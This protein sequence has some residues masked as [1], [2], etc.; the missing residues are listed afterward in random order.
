MLTRSAGR[1][2]DVLQASN[3]KHA[4]FGLIKCEH[5]LE[6]AQQVTYCYCFL[7]LLRYVPCDVVNISNITNHSTFS[8]NALQPSSFERQSINLTVRIFND[9]VA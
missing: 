3:P 8:A 9:F 1:T 2:G 6:M 5:I 4:F 7:Q